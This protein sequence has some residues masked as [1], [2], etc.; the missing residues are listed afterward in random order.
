MTS[1]LTLPQLLDGGLVDD[2]QR[3]ALLAPGRTPLSRADL[4]RQLAAA[5]A[6]LRQAGIGRCD[7]VAV[8]LRNGPELAAISL[9]V[10]SSARCAP[11]NPAIT[12]GEFGFYLGDLEPA[13][14]LLAATDRGDLRSVAA[15]L[16]VRCLDVQ[17]TA[18][19]P[20]GACAIK[21][22]AISGETNDSEL[23]NPDDVALL[24]HT[25]G[26]T[27]RP[28]L[29]PLTHRNLCASAKNVIRTLG[30]SP[31]DRSLNLMPLF[32]IHGFVASLLAS[33]AAGGSVACCA[34][35]RDGEFIPCLDV[36]Q[37]TWYT[38]APAIHRAVL[39]ELARYPNR[40]AA[41][42]LRFVRSASAPL[43]GTVMRALEAALEAPVIEAY[44]MTEAAHQI[45]S[46]PLPPGER[47]ARSVGRAT[48]TSVAV[49]DEAQRLLPAGATGE[50]V[51]RGDNVTAG[52]ASPRGANANAFADGWFRTGDIGSIDADGCIHITG[53]LKELINRA[54][55][56]VSPLE[57]DEAL[58][59]HPDVREVVAFGVEHPTMGE[60]VAAAVVLKEGTAAS[61]NE[62]RA[63]LFGR[64][65][66]FK[67]PSQILLVDSVPVGATGKV[68]RANLPS[69][70]ASRMRPAFVSPRDQAEHELAALFREILGIAEVGAFDNFFTLGGDSLRGFQLL[71]RIREQWRV[72]IPMVELFKEPTLAQLAVATT[73]ARRSDE[74]TGPRKERHPVSGHRLVAQTLAALGITHVY[75][76]PGQPVYG[77][78]GACAEVGLRTIGT[79]HQLA[80][81]MMAVAHNYLAGRQRAVALVSAGAPAA[82]TLGGVAL[83][84]SNGWPLLVLAGAAR[85]TAERSGHFM[86]LDAAELSRSIAKSVACAQATEAIPATLRAAF[87][88]VMQGRPGPVV[89]QLPEQALAGFAPP[90]DDEATI[91]S[92]HARVAPDPVKVDR[93]AALLLDA[94]RPLLI[95]GAGTRWD[96]PYDALREL[97]DTLEL[98]FIT[99]PLGRGTIPDGHPLCM[100]PI[101][102]VA[103][104]R[105]DLAL[106]LGARLNWTF[107]HGRQLAPDATIVQVDIHAPELDGERKPTIG[108][109]SDLGS[110]LRA[111]RANAAIRARNAAACGDRDWVASLSRSRAQMEEKRAARAT[112]AQLPMSPLRLAKELREALPCD[113]ITILDGNL[114]MEAME[115]AIPVNEPASRLTPGASGCLGIGVPFAL[116]AKLV[117]PQRAVIAICGDFAFG[118]SAMDL[119]TAVRHNVPIVVVVANNDGNMGALRQKMYM[120]GGAEPIMRFQPGLRYDRIME[121]FGGHAEHVDRPED[122]RSAVERALA[123]R[124]PACIN[125]AVDPDAPFPG[126]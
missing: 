25:S 68:A 17:W 29:V 8:V 51:I 48:G 44:G 10:A 1:A 75:G 41:A 107:R 63:F 102:W 46:N 26:T 66:E 93:A 109:E 111:L 92:S 24:L 6:A 119:E 91:S 39:A 2:G 35:Y 116:A 61:A 69:L 120:D 95:V 62:I 4:R 53:R 13:A 86:A 72:D 81:A 27:S 33:L 83:A 32:H 14:L 64:L 31:R 52:Y 36:L 50:I 101:R 94:Q 112:T 96:A 122:I 108:I 73:R 77:T 80:A 15:S 87:D 118:M 76:V 123:S 5:H 100:N 28:K 19:A 21:G 59:E 106:V 121:M 37:P 115:Q 89:L 124:R 38:A 99:S 54:G 40:I 103:Q 9:A 20:A 90:P 34:G 88:S 3:S 45:A 70:L 49:M 126:D 79:R 125:V 47:Q 82:N 71:T 67:I 65:A 98:P 117:Y 22:V 56:K 57:I 97:I 16:G 78:F 60:D 43:P 23:P 58:L 55:E 110:F 42:R 113:A 11:L 18:D 7:T 104:S 85:D 30:L 84:R 12:A 105:A 74:A 114:V